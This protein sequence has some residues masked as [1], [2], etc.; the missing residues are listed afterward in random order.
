MII[1]DYFMGASKLL[2]LTLFC[3]V[4][5]DINMHLSTD[6]KF[7]ALTSLE[8]MEYYKLYGSLAA[9]FKTHR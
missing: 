9:F 8:Q 3:F 1:T 2:D 4:K 6:S 5:Q 7:R